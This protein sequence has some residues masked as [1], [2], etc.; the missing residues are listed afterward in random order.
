MGSCIFYIERTPGS[1]CA[2]TMIYRF[3]A[4]GWCLFFSF[5]IHFLLLL[6]LFVAENMLGCAVPSSINFHLINKIRANCGLLEAQNIIVFWSKAL[7]SGTETNGLAIQVV[8]VPVYFPSISFDA[9]MAYIIAMVPTSNKCPI[10]YAIYPGLM[11]NLC[12]FLTWYPMFAV[13]VRRFK[14]HR[15]KLSY[16]NIFQCL[17]IY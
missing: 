7:N 13:L 1:R 4:I 8:Y 16:T 15:D 2:A 11:C 14:R 17:S 12:L 10:T 5:F 9:K 3:Y 6:L